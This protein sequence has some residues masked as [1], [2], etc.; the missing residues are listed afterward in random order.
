MTSKNDSTLRSDLSTNFADNTS[1]AITESVYRSFITD[2]F[3]SGITKKYIT[4]VS[5][6]TTLS[7]VHNVVLVDTSGGAVTITLP[8]NA[9]EANRVFYIKNISTNAVTINRAGTDTIEGATSLSLSSQWDLA[10]LLSD[11]AGQWVKLN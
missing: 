10:I 5:G 4:T 7:N 8:D 1:G 6:A 2:I 11:G 9:T 3:D